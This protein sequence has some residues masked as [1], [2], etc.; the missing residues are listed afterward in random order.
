MTMEPPGKK[1]KITKQLRHLLED[2]LVP[3]VHNYYPRT[4]EGSFGPS[5]DYCRLQGKE[6]EFYVKKEYIFSLKI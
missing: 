4:R 3:E 1:L 5:L 6:E 2:E